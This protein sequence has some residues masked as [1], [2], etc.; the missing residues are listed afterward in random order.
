LVGE[1]GCGKSTLGRIVAG[2]MPQTA[3]TMTWR[4]KDVGAMHG[5]E[6]RA[7][8]LAVQ[9]IFQDPYA[10]LNPR[11]RVSEIVGEA[12]RVH[13][14]VSRGAQGKYVAD[15]LDQVGL[16]GA[17]ATRYPHQFSGGQR[18]RIG[19]ARA[20]AVKPSFIV[21]DEAVAALDVSIQAQVLN[22]LLRLQAEFGLTI[23]L[24]SHDIRVVGH[25]SHEI[26]VMSAGV[27]V[28]Q[29]PAQQVIKQPRN[30]YS[31]ALFDAAPGAGR[32]MRGAAEAAGVVGEG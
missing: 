8:Q 14:L 20:L 9:M 17:Y 28:E 23:I 5:S 12:P 29:G 11:L 2:I 19:I 13:G 22:L 18:Q 15:M 21:C 24:I 31:R 1:S 3:G 27:M 32:L 25:M 7:W 30:A 4:G 10:S 26:G 6:R 16:D